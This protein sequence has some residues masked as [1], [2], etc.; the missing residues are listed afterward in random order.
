MPKTDPA[1]L[2]RIAVQRNANRPFPV[3][4]RSTWRGR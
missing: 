3:P 4:T 2:E 1:E